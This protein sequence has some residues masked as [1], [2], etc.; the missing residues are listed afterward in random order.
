MTVPCNL[1][2]RTSQ[3]TCAAMKASSSL[4]VHGVVSLSDAT[5]AFFS[6]SRV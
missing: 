6:L 4:S 3:D 1:E 2:R 5:P